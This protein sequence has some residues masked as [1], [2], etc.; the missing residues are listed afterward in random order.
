VVHIAAAAVTLA[1]IRGGSE[2]EPDSIARASYIADHATTWRLAWFVWMIAAISLI[3][4]Y[5][6]WAAK[7][8]RPR[9]ALT[10]L[11]FGF[12][13]I[14]VD[15]F[16][17]ALFIGWIPESYATYAQFTTT[18]SEVVANGLYSVA[19]IILMFASPPMRPWF[20]AWGWTVWMA[21]IALSIAGALRWNEAIVVASALLLTTFIPWVWLASRLIE[22]P[23]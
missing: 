15:F 14:A 13:G 22:E 23:L 19:G 17:D 2:A 21:G 7:S 4:F 20:R 18:M 6:W 9:L 10:A 5:S 3:G 16:A 12:A 11:F 1:W 8:A